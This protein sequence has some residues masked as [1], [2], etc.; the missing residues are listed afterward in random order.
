MLGIEDEYVALGINMA[1]ALTHGELERTREDGRTLSLASALV[2][3]KLPG[4][5]NE[6]G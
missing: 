5:E 3:G 2:L 4:R 6:N 1:A